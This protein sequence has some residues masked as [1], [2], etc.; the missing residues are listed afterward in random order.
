MRVRKQNDIKDCGPLVVQALH[1]H[2][3][4]TEPKLNELKMKVSYGEKG[5]NVKNLIYLLKEY[6]I[7][8]EAYEADVEQ[9]MQNMQNEYFIAII[10]SENMSH[11]IIVKIIGKT[12][13][14][15]DSVKGNYKM[16]KEEFTGAYLGSLIAIEKGKYTPNEI[17]LT[18]PMQYLSKNYNFIA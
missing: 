6:G 15:Y 8:S 1:K 16:T 3:Y 11:Y 9:L 5:I 7:D 17:D 10:N 18:S 13:H 2:F 4:S 12:F 14:I